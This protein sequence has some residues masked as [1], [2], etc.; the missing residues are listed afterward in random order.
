LVIRADAF[1]RENPGDENELRRL[2][3]LKLAIVPAEG[4]P[5]RRQA[6]QEECSEAEWSLAKRLADYPY[7]LVVLGE[8]GADGRVIAE[9]AHEA[10]L[11]AWPR[12]AEWLREERD[13][14]VFKSE[15]ERAERRWRMLH[16]VDQAL[17]SGFDLVSAEDWLSRRPGDLSAEATSYV[18][19]S[20]ALDKAAR[21]R[22]QL[23]A[24]GNKLLNLAEKMEIN[25]SH[26]ESS[27][28]DEVII[29][30]LSSLLLLNPDNVFW[31]EELA[32]RNS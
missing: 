2:L 24:A 16:K 11:R 30:L 18:Q 31:R 23:I 25:S 28:C 21:A 29:A 8:R 20:I 32:A 1:L 26:V 13:F 14:L 9:V 15:V 19:R 4:E 5:M 3:T 22:Q 6:S 10:I 27:Q 17:L 7:R 12:L